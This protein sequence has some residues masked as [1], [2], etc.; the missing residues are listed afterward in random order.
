MGVAV[1]EAGS[2]PATYSLIPDLLPLN[3][4]PG[5]VGLLYFSGALGIGLSLFLGGLLNVAL[6]WRGTLI[7]VAM[8]G[9]LLALLIRL[10][11]DEPKRQEEVV[12]RQPV[13]EA[14]REL[15]RFPSF[16]C[17][18]LFAIFGAFVGYGVV[19]W[20]PTF[21]IRVHKMAVPEVGFWIGISMAFGSGVGSFAAGRIANRLIKR[22]VRLLFLVI[23]LSTS[24]ALP[25]GL[26]FLFAPTSTISVVAF[27]I[28]STVYGAQQPIYFTIAL[29]LARGRSRGLSAVILTLFQN[30]GGVALGPLMV[31]LLN[32][33]LH[34]RFGDGAIR[35]SLAIIYMALIVAVVIS[36]IGSRFIRQDYA[37]AQAQ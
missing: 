23:A 30:I 27:F 25:L 18:S 11:V 5:A 21:L 31:G 3:K 24:L 9:F 28:Y 35:Y 36:L 33:N 1:G 26:L 34:P 10:T 17:V 22:D 8:P 13:L 29:I 32:D 12:T 16:K 20:A 2:M 7:A 14:L 4:R 6:G 37:I 19:G 15:W